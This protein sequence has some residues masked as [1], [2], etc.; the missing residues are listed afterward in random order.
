MNTIVVTPVEHSKLWS[1][2]FKTRRPYVNVFVVHPLE[3]SGRPRRSPGP[4]LF[5]AGL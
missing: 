4:F 3:L 5:V 1:K 2:D